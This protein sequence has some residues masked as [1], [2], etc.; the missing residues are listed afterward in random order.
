M[1]LILAYKGVSFV[2]LVVQI[3]IGSD[4]LNVIFE[5]LGQ[6]IDVILTIFCNVALMWVYW[7][8]SHSVAFSGHQ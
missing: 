5:D 8:M 3:G 6:T 7:K 4:S 2:Y 1:G